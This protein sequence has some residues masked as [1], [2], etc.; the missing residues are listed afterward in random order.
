MQLLGNCAKRELI[1]WPHDEENIQSHGRTFMRNM[2]LAGAVYRSEKRIFVL[3]PICDVA[4]R[5]CGIQ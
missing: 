2:D 4:I 1:N 3:N 5:T